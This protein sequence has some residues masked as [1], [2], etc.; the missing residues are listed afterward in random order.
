[1]ESQPEK[2]YRRVPPKIAKAL[3]VCF[4]YLEKSPTQ[5]F[6]RIKRLK[7]YENLYRY[8]VGD[9][10]VVYEIHEIKKEVAVVAILPRGDVYKN[11]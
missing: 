1:M 4:I 2:Y 7:G 6:S 11:L 10:R 8:R 5:H 3:E 9:L